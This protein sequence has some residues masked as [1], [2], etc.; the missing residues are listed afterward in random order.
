MPELLAKWRYKKIALASSALL[1]VSAMS[2]YTHFQ[3]S[4]WRNSLTL[5][6]HAI[7]VTGNNYTAHLGIAEPLREQGRLNEA[8]G[9][10]RKYLQLRPGEP[11]GLNGLGIAFGQQGKLDESINCFTQA[12]RIKP[13]FTEA[14]INLGRA[15][16][17]QGNLDEAAIHL[18]EAIRLDPHSAK[19]H[20]YIGQVLVQKDKINEAITHFEK[21]L[22]LEPDWF[23]P[24]N[25]LAWYLAASK[26]R[27]VRN[28]DKAVRLAQWACELTNYKKPELLDTLAVSY[29][30]TGD[31]GKAIEMAEK[32][33]ELCQSS[34]QETLKAKIENR[35][36]LFKAGKPYIETQ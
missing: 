22:Q 7:D 29:A 14:H 19:V 30:A 33:L 12:L 15:L 23:E 21:A 36:V 8:I 25:D 11:S 6:Q 35:L 13:D 17:L 28:P 26:E 3:L 16:T 27:T 2:L 24:M 34:E 20:Y 4:Y 10:Y 9:E 5:F 32:A 31:F 1:I 18:A